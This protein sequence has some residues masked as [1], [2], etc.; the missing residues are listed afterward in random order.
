MPPLATLE[1][2]AEVPAVAARTLPP[3][4]RRITISARFDGGTYTRSIRPDGRTCWQSTESLGRVLSADTVDRYHREGRVM[5]IDEAD[6]RHPGE[7]LADE[8]EAMADDLE[9]MHELASS[10]IGHD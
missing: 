3:T 2:A 5:V 6:P 4:A 10:M 7:F 1:A 9:A 8:I